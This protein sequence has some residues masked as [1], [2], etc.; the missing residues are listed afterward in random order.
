MQPLKI[1]LT[2]GIASGKSSV[3]RLFNQKAIA[4]IDTD[5][6]ARDLF[7]TN[8][9]LLTP[10][11]SRFGDDIFDSEGELN[12]KSLGKRVFQS[13]QDLTWLNELIHPKISEQI[14]RQLKLVRSQYVIIDIPL[15]VNTTGKVSNHLL[16]FIDRILVIDISPALQTKR[17]CQRDNTN[18]KQALLVQRSQSS[19]H[20]KLR[21]AND[22]IDNNGSIAEL[23]YQVSLFHNHYL[24]LSSE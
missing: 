23:E 6:I 18:I 5:Q 14:K 16:P 10:L 3:S 22:V 19:P 24:N 17:Q 11:R 8:A 13:E 2:G 7:K 12:R 21:L 20:Q 1:A 15:L 9:P 4:L